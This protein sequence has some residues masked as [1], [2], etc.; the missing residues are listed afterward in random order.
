MRKFIRILKQHFG[1]TAPHVAVHTEIPW[2]WRALVIVMLMV[3][4]YGVGYWRFATNNANQ[5][6]AEVQ[7]LRAENK[8]LKEKAV[9][10]ERQQQVEH[11][12][13]SNLAREMAALQDESLRLK[14]DLAF[15]KGI[16][17]EGTG[18]GVLKVNSFKLAKG[19]TEGEYLYTIILVQSGKHDKT[20][21]GSL[22]LV[23]NGLQAGKPT[24]VVVSQA[25]PPLKGVKVNFRYYQRIEGKFTIPA[26]VTGQSLQARFFEPGMAQ[27]KLTQTVNLTAP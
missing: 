25:Q 12:A 13:Q 20:I 26:Q 1:V 17:V 5:L 9:Y 23:L 21:Q 6:A 24:E 3:L 11:A 14:E 16:M 2:Y 27:P 18:T 8:T 4:G 7:Q 22:Q 15:Y 10:A 19:A